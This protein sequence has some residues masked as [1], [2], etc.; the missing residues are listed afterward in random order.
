GFARSSGNRRE[1]GPL[2]TTA[3][4]AIVRD[5]GHTGHRVTARRNSGTSL[6]QNGLGTRGVN[7]ERFGS[8]PASAHAGARADLEGSAGRA[9]TENSRRSRMDAAYV[10]DGIGGS[11]PC[12]SGRVEKGGDKVNQPDLPIIE[13]LSQ[14]R[15][16][17]TGALS[18]SCA[19]QRITLPLRSQHI[20]AKTA[21]RVAEVIVEQ[22]FQNPF[23][24]F[25]EAVY[26]FP[27]GGGAAVSAFEMK[28]GGRTLKAMI[29]ERGE[30]RQD[31]QNALEKG[32][33]AALLEQ[34]RDNVFT[35]QVGNLPPGEEVSVRII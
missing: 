6:F 11:D 20:V 14:E 28:V 27:L 21:D 29:K 17:E 34:D 10:R 22:S 25:L 33:R 8:A 30:A 24:E 31:Y 15:T 13:K 3:C 5:Q 16:S 4:F 32:K 26:I 7:R 23:Q 1:R 19:D 18:V 35:V 2:W 12:G 9:G